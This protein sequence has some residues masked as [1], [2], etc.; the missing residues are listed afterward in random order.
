MAGP[1]MSVAPTGTTKSPKVTTSTTKNPVTSGNSRRGAARC[2]AR[3]GGGTATVA[4]EG[5]LVAGTAG[6][7][8]R[9][10]C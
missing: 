7:R 10:G 8:E 1:C 4:R 5:T 9:K 3:L 6:D 2:S